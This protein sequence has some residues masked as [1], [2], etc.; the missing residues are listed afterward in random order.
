[1]KL[2]LLDADDALIGSWDLSAPQGEAD[3]REIAQTVASAGTVDAVGHR[4]VHGG[5]QFLGPV[6]VDQQVVTALKALTDLAPL[7]QP[8]SLAALEA[9]S[10]ALPD[11]PAV[12]C[13]D[14]AFHAEM[15]EAA[16]TYALPAAWRQRWKIGRASCR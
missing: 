7:H 3:E 10:R 1:M 12:A 8:K 4:I 14:T 9:V 13:F 15:P 2:R 6:I 5:T 16:S 11:I